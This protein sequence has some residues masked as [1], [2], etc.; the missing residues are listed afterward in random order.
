MAVQ[1]YPDSSFL[2]SLHRADKNQGAAR[3]Y[4]AAHPRSLIFTPLH[5]IEVRNA[6]RNLAARGEVTEAELRTALHQLEQDLHEEIL[7]HTA[8]P[9]TNIFRRADELSDAHAGRHGQRTIDLLHVATA[10]ECAAT[11]F[12]SFD[13][14]QRT[15]AHAAGL[16]VKP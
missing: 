4:M 5:R 9:W 1:T 12:L 6:F 15:L 2:V 11:T 13:V 8:I 7:V 16:Q 3:S 10:I 14:R